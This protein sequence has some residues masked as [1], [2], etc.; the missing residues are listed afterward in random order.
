MALNNFG[1][2]G[3]GTPQPGSHSNNAEFHYRLDGDLT[4]SGTGSVYGNLTGTADTAPYFNVECV[5]TT[6][7]IH[8]GSV[9]GHPMKTGAAVTIAAWVFLNA[10]PTANLGVCGIRG[11]GGSGDPNT[12]NFCWELGITSAGYARFFWQHGAKLLG[13][14]DGVIAHAVPLRQWVHLMG[15][16]NAAGTECQLWVDGVQV[17]SATG[18]TPFDGGASMNTMA[19]GNNGTTKMDGYIASVYGNLG[20]TTDGASFYSAAKAAL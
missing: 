3:G 18:Q 14:L 7:V 15:T 11:G 9:S 8:S 2:G 12:H 5:R 6:D 20:Q 19:V 17:G 16:R 10:N 1:G 13:G 4:D